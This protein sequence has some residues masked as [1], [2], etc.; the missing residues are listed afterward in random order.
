MLERPTMEPTERSMPRCD[1]HQRH[2]DGDHGV[3]RR[4]QHDVDQ[5]GLLVE[6]AGE[7]GE[8]RKKSDAAD[9]DARLSE[10]VPVE[11]ARLRLRD[12]SVRP[13]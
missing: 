12:A 2:A 3:D 8:D 13:R 1:D 4:L 10:V 9:Q 6:A 7:H 11:T 5:V